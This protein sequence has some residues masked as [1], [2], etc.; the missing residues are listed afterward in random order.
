MALTGHSGPCSES[1]IPVS[2]HDSDGK[3]LRMSPEQQSLRSNSISK[4]LPDLGA[5]RSFGND[6]II[7][8]SECTSPRVRGLYDYWTKHRGDRLMPRRQD[9]D[10]VDIWTAAPI[11]ALE[12]VAQQSRT[13]FSFGSPA[14][15]S[16]ATAGQEFRGR[17][18][19]RDH[20]EPAGSRAGR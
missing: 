12:R 18:L 15:V 6:V 8:P 4:R 9:I 1:A 13:A 19:E 14:P 2:Y 10:P 17:W 16:V 3:W 7:S 20:A 5:E 11:P